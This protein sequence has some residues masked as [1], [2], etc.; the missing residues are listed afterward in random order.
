MSIKVEDSGSGAAMRVADQSPDINPLLFWKSYSKKPLKLNSRN[1]RVLGGKGDRLC[2]QT[3]DQAC[4]E[5][6]MRRRRAART[7]RQPRLAVSL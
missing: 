4:A 1:G 7:E 3:G 2:R 6:R 5:F